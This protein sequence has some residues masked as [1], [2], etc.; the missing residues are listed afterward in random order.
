MGGGGADSSQ[1][2][3]LCLISKAPLIQWENVSRLLEGY[4]STQKMK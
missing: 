4:F 3:P 2:I 1:T